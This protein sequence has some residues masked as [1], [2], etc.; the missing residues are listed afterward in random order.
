MFSAIIFFILSVI[1]HKNP[2][3]FDYLCKK[4]DR[5]PNAL[6]CDCLYQVQLFS[7]IQI[8]KVYDTEI[9]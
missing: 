8:P 2:A 9:Y 1:E 5:L 6:R 4:F 7:K 3:K